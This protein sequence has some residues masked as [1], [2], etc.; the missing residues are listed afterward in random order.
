MANDELSERY[1]RQILFA[2]IG[3]RGSASSASC[4][5][6]SSLEAGALG[7]V[8]VETLA[9]AGIG[10]LR[11]IDRDYVEKSNLHRQILYTGTGRG[12]RGPEGGGGER[13]V[14]DI[15]SEVQVEGIVDD[16]NALSVERLLHGGRPDTRCNRQL[17]D[18]LPAERRFVEAGIPWVYGAVVG[19]GGATMDDSSG[20]NTV[21]PMSFRNDAGA[22]L[23]S[24]VRHCRC[25]SSGRSGHSL[26][27][28]G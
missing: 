26:D 28:G 22:W 3:R 1:S 2:G 25:G 12:G 7:A 15:N 4:Q 19:G 20:A 6:R 14:R 10:R 23:G 16:V 24:D 18:P 9:R 8:H 27:T 21:P 17:R 5:C 13:R 11:I